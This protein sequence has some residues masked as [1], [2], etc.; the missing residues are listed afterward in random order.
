[1]SL[2]GA[3]W[4]ELSKYNFALKG[5]SSDLQRSLRVKIFKQQNFELSFIK[6]IHIERYWL[7]LHILK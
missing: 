3:R 2:G 6:K 1:M 5:K 7:N 4:W